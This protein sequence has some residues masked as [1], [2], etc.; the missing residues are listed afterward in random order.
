MTLEDFEYL[1]RRKSR[2]WN[3]FN[4]F[5]CAGFICFG[6]YMFISLSGTAT[7]IIRK[8]WLVVFSLFLILPAVYALYVLRN[9]HKVQTWSNTLT[10]IQNMALLEW[11]LHELGKSPG[12]SAPP[13]QHIA[14]IYQK[15]WWRLS[16]SVHLFA[17][18]NCIAIH[19]DS[20]R[21]GV[22]GMVDFG[23]SKRLQRKIIRML[24]Q[25]AA[26]I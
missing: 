23:A 2:S 24:K 26:S 13:K 9:N 17:D 15:S 10:R 11:L 7:T 16:Y 3:Y 6:L 18:L 8:I 20:T 25:R 19:A 22:N 12:L 21:Y 1:I 4:Y 5:I 14:F